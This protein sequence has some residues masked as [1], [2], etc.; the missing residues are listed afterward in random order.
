ME[1]IFVQDGKYIDYTPVSAV[2][3]GDVV[4]IGNIPCVATSPI[5]AGV[6]GAV[7]SEGVF[8][9]LKGSETYT[10]GD[11]VYWD[12][13]GTP[14]GGSTTGCATDNAAL[15]YLMG[16]AVVD[17]ASGDSTV[18][19]RL[20]AA[21]R[22]TTIAGSCTADA[23][24]GSDSSLGI[25]GQQAE[26]G[27]AV[28]ITGGTSTTATNAG[29][30]ITIVGGTPGATSAG[31][32]ISITAGAGGAT[33]GAGG[34]VSI[35]AGAGTAGNGNG[36]AVSILG[37]NAHGS[38]TDGAISIGTSNTSAITISATSIP[39]TIA[40]P[41]TGG[42]G[43]S[44]EAAGSSSADAAELPAGTAS[45]YPTTGANDSTGVIINAADKVTGRMLFIGNGVSN[46]ILK[47]YPP[48]GGSING[49][50]A[51]AAFS[52]DSGKG[53]IVVCLSSG[54]NTWL[55]W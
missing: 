50:S 54:D 39:T 24:A 38:G 14:T 9:V 20:T 44:T 5:A 35:A 7:A 36:G 43:V 42:I 23:I 10:A 11:A 15:G 40:G 30:A 34:A 41:I 32:A 55:A 6:L 27:G 28:V 33:S 12:E 37:G 1:A 4:V 16:F 31:G 52:S 22:T 18:T 8:K 25:S 29:G 13:D 49:G 51:N 45:V 48:S 19:V 26:Q 17:A 46:K 21:T 2:S 53:V 3:T 47:V